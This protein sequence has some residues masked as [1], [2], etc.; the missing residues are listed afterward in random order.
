M[1]LQAAG[2][3][4]TRA[5]QLI[6]TNLWSEKVPDL[7]PRLP[8][9]RPWLLCLETHPSITDCPFSRAAQPPYLPLILCS[10]QKNTRFRPRAREEHF[11]SPPSVLF[12]GDFPI[13]APSLSS[14]SSGTHQAAEELGP[15]GE[16]LPRKALL[17]SLIHRN[18]SKSSFW[19]NTIP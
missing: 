17:G 3:L 6:K 19:L 1:L 16:E 12:L 9:Q 14:C 13:G 10:L 15:P 5:G 7:L 11:F 4:L 8:Q 18:P 2:T